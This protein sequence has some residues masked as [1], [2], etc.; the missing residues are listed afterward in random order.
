MRG[1]GALVRRVTSSVYFSS[2]PSLPSFSAVAVFRTSPLSSSTSTSTSAEKDKRLSL[3]Y[4]THGEP[5]QVLRLRKLP[6]KPTLGEGELRVRVIAA[7]I[8]PADINTV[9]GVYPLKPR[10][11]IEGQGEGQGEGETSYAVGGSEGVGV[12]VEERSGNTKVGDVVV[13][14]VANLGTWSE[15]FVCDQDDIQVVSV[16]S[17][18]N[19][20]NSEVEKLANVSVCWS[21][22]YRM[23]EDFVKLE[24]GDYV[25]QNG[26]NSAVGQAVIQLAKRRGLRSINLIRDSE[27]TKRYVFLFSF[28]F[29][30]L[31]CFIQ[32]T[33]LLL[34]FQVSAQHWG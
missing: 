9:Q 31:F 20:S 18:C 4:E 34:L 33:R 29:F 28:W 22:A 12:V 5:D 10:K 7:S 2:L 21:T 16:A 17:K 25:I 3:V 27:E 8:N 30:W 13:P 15:E 24:R 19:R 6:V 26:A 14:V 1:G 23:L 32:L 11:R